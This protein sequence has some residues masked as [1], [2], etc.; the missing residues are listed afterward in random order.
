VIK[1]GICED[2][3]LA[4]GGVAPTT[5]RLRKTEETLKGKRIKGEALENAA[6]LAAGEIRPISDVRA[7]AQYRT[8]LSKVLVKHVLETS[9][10][11]AERRRR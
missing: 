5:M 7:T 3:R 9:A 1:D 10:E 4:L 8:E 11:R 2:V 6:D